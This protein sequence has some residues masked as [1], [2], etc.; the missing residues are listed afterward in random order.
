MTVSLSRKDKIIQT[1]WSLYLKM[2]NLICIVCQIPMVEMFATSMNH[3]LPLYVLPVPDA[4]VLNID[5]LNILLEGLYCYAFFLYHS[6]Q[7]VIEHAN[8]CRCKMI[9]VAPRWSMMHWFWDLVNQSTKPPLQLLHWSQKQ[10]F[11]QKYHQNLHWFLHVWHLNTTQNHLNHSLSRCLRASQGPSSCK[12][13]SQDGPFE[14]WYPQN[15][16]AIS[17]P[18]VSNIPDFLIHLLSK[19]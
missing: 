5:A 12:C 18:T 9:V 1:G 3:K 7:K 17:E 6:F 14:L 19:I 2:F 4:N 11:S 16:V 10:P 13:I 15:K 8:T